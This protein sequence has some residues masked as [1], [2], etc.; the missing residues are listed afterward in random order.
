MTV[1]DVCADLV[2]HPLRRVIHRWHWK[3]ATLSAILR[4]SI[5]FATNL[6]DGLGIALRATL[7]DAVFRVPL[8]GACA[9]VTQ[10]F[11]C[12]EPPWVASLAVM[13]LLPAMAHV[14]EFL[15][16]WTAGTPELGTSMLASIVFSALSTVF[17]LFA[18]RRGVLIV[19]GGSRSFGDD[20]K[21][22]PRLVLDFILVPP[23]ALA[24]VL[25]RVSHQRRLGP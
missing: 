3:G 16:H 13:A 6:P 20:L 25:G 12:A 21:H 10:A 24:R 4:G 2:R 14:I 7:V 15:V 22:I 5:F 9:A 1:W 8:V 11:R 23:R 17:N 18:M 19:G